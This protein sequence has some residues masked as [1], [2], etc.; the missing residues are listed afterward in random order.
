MGVNREDFIV[1]GVNIGMDHYDEDK[2][3]S[4]EKL[5]R[6][7]TVGEMTYL[8]DWMCGNY[9]V[10]GEV[11]S[12]GDEYEGFGVQEVNISEKSDERVADFIRDKFG[13]DVKPK[14]IVISHLT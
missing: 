11:V 10:V 12:H 5:D 7:S 4:Y 9:F 3:E 6:Q 14:I 8:I 1:I 13:I 2:F